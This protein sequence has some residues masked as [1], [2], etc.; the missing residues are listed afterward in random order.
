MSRNRFL[1]V[2]L[3]PTVGLTALP[4]VLA[5]ATGSIHWSLGLVALINALV[6]YGDLFGF[7]L[8]LFQIPSGALVKNNGYRSYW[9]YPPQR[10]RCRRNRD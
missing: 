6:L 10:R 4:L 8:I 2:L 1:A 3:A 9:R 7:L 5:W